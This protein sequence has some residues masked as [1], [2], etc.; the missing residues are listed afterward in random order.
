LEN[1]LAGPAAVMYYLGGS[2][3]DWEW[4]TPI[5]LA[6]C[7]AACRQAGVPILVDAANM[8]PP[9]GNIP[10]LAAAGVDLIAISGGKHLRGPQCSG[11]LAGRKD[12]VRAAWL[13]SSPHSDSQGRPM[14][15]GREEVVGVWLAAEKYAKLDFDRIDRESAA[16]A[17]Y[18]MRQLGMLD[19]VTVAKTPF[20]RT[21]RVHRVHVRW[22]EARLGITAEHAQKL[23]REGEPRIAIGRAQPQGLEL[24][25]FM[26][27]AGD[28]KVAARRLKEV[29]T[30]R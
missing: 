16:Q 6:D 5:P 29:L 18:L 28:E 2:S 1:A 8:L 17:A 25:V 15:V 3:H 27:D 7:V 21:R 30:R 9:W 10:K 14:K 4:E 12:L 11:I 23:L 19:G 13:N 22:D 26:N 20:D 24:T